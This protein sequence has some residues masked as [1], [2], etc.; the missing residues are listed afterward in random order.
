VWQNYDDGPELQ[1]L[2]MMMK[3]IAEDYRQILLNFRLNIE[4]KYSTSLA[5]GGSGSRFGVAVKK[6][7]GLT[8][9]EDVSELRRKLSAGTNA[10]MM[11][12]LAAM[13]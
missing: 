13:G 4:K 2:G 1:E 12:V 6:I 11:L 9:K 3:D 10:I 7:L 8:E 5:P